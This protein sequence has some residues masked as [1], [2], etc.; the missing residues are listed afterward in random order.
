MDVDVGAYRGAKP[1]KY[2]PSYSIQWSRSEAEEDGANAPQD[3]ANQLAEPIS[4]PRAI[5]GYV[6]ER[7]RHWGANPDELRGGQQKRMRACAKA[8]G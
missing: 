2:G 4:G 7:V 5:G 1:A 3:P 6:N 8:A